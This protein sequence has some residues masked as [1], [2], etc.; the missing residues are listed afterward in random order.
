MYIFKIQRN[1]HRKFAPLLQ[2]LT[3]SVV[4]IAPT[5]HAQMGQPA[6]L[7][8]LTE[9]ANKG[10]TLEQTQQWLIKTY[11]E[12]GAIGAPSPFEPTER[13]RQDLHFSGCNVSILDISAYLNGKYINPPTLRSGSLLDMNP[14]DVSFTLGKKETFLRHYSTSLEI[15]RSPHAFPA[16]LGDVNAL[17][18]M[19]LLLLSVKPERTDWTGNSLIVD[20]TEM[21][22]RITSAWRHAIKLC[23]EQA[24][25]TR[26]AVPVKPAGELF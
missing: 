16:F 18:K 21:G 20:F 3:I 10:P 11:R 17:E 25:A 4:L 6:P 12:M 5:S 1:H 8:K 22:P 14:E 24:A 2:A 26:N 15:T 19:R 23:V 9:P 7:P 13:F